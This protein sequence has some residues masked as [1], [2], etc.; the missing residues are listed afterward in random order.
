MKKKSKIA[1]GLTATIAAGAMAISLPSLAH[2]REDGSH[3]GRGFG[4]EASAK[5]ERAVNKMASAN[6]AT[7][8]ASITGIPT[9]ISSLREA[10]EGANFEVYRLADD[11]TSVPDTKPDE[12]A[13]VV[14][15][16]PS[17]DEAGNIDIPEI[18]NGEINAAI[19]FKAPNEEGV[20][21]LA[22]Y[23]SDGSAAILVTLTTDADGTTVATAS[24]DLTVAFN[25]EV[26]DAF[27]PSKMGKGGPGK[28]RMGQGPR[29]DHNHE[30]PAEDSADLES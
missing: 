13:W 7:V 21:K 19:G 11:A 25:Q 5:S 20:S 27:E 1:I 12:K 8:E 16:R 3:Q 26:A 17:M 6:F 30:M 24:S 9:D 18:A 14:S 22:L 29:H 23:P 4:V 10:A 15:I 2:D 28:G